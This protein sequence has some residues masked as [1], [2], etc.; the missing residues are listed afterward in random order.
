[1][2]LLLIAIL[3]IWFQ[4]SEDDHDAVIAVFKVYQQEGLR[5]EVNFDIEDFTTIQ[6]LQPSEVTPNYLSSYLKNKTRWSVGDRQLNIEVLSIAMERDHFKASCII[7]NAPAQ[8]SNLIIQNEFLLEVEDHSNIMMI[9][10]NETTKDFRMHEK[11]KE[12][13]INY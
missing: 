12:L 5:L 13:I 7:A 3:S 6:A 10:L 11:R 8:I 1:M 9:D 2:K 4:P